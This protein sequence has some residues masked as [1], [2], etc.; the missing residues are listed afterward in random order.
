MYTL[1]G[2]S[3]L[4]LDVTT[5]KGPVTM[6]S[7]PPYCGS[8]AG[9]QQMLHDLGYYAGAVDGAFGKNS[10]AAARAFALDNSLP[11][12]GVTPAFCDTLAAAWTAKKGGAGA[13]GG[14]SSGGLRQKFSMYSASA[15]KLTPAKTS[16][17]T[18][19]TEPIAT[20]PPGTWESWGVGTKVAVV[21]GALALLGGGYWYY[22][23]KMR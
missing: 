16:Q 9:L 12:S 20:E 14:G 8:P 21:G 22:T 7:A 5:P 10:L 19:Y 1:V 18:V 13:A 3:G 17:S 6:T 15:M 11:T 23:K 4:G 2:Y